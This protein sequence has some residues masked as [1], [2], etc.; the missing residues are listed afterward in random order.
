MISSFFQGSVFPC[1]LIP[2]TL[3]LL[4]CSASIRRTESARNPTDRECRSI[5]NI[6]RGKGFT[7]PWW[8]VH[9]KTQS[10]T[11][12]GCSLVGKSGKCCQ[13]NFDTASQRREMSS[14]FSQNWFGT[15]LNTAGEVFKVQK[16]RFDVTFKALLQRAHTDFHS[17]FERT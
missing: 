10:L 17:M 1:L 7:Y 11:P 5:E 14:A 2:A 13:Q 15:K 3:L 4:I 9:S 12:S 16:T 8:D 6:L